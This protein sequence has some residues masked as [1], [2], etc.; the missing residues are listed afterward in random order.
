MKIFD[1]IIS[2][3]FEKTPPKIDTNFLKKLEKENFSLKNV[4]FDS[5]FV[6]GKYE[7]ILWYLEL[8]KF[9]SD[10]KFSKMFANI[11]ENAIKKSWK[12][13]SGYIFVP[14]PMHWSRYFIRGFDTMDLIVKRLAKNTSHRYE[15]ILG[16]RFSRRQIF[17]SRQNRHKNRVWKFYIKKWKNIPK[18]VVLFDDIVTTGSTVNECA[19]V[20]KNAWVEKIYIFALAINKS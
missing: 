9:H 19:K 17:L 3:F 7:E 2:V 13:F 8:Y 6:A 10:R 18:K 20:L 15:Y 14:V 1:E 5:V 4:Y 12:D 11:F 16:T